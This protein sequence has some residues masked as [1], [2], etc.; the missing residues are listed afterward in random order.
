M[1]KG[2][3]VDF[4]KLDINNTQQIEFIVKNVRD[5]YNKDIAYWQYADTDLSTGLYFAQKDNIFIASQ[6]MIPIYLNVQG[7]KVL[8]AKSESSFLLPNYRGQGIFEKLYSHTIEKSSQSSIH[9]FWGFTSLS[10]VWRRLLSFEV[11]DSIIQESELQISLYRSIFAIRSGS[12]SLFDKCKKLCK[13]IYSEIKLKKRPHIYAEFSA[14]FLDLNNSNHISLIC[15]L[16][17]MWS[18]NHPDYVSMYCDH[19]YIKWRVADNP[20]TKY[21]IIGIYK[22]NL[23]IGMCILNDRKGKSYML[24]FIVSDIDL[25]SLSFDTL[26]LF[27]KKHTLI[28][29]IIYWA[30][31]KNDY[32][33]K[34]HKLMKKYGA[35]IYINEN[36]NF[37]IKNISGTY[38]NID[39]SKYY[40]NG[41]WTEGFKI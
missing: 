23:L 36:M 26:L 8:T 32:S 38:D 27:V 29:H 20:I 14:S 28:S 30:S 1:D 18:I 2:N 3:S 21:E 17:K 39:I 9:C 41:L 40:L 11:F 34:I 24:D 12:S 19:S 33:N 13:S 37:V 35:F 6:G 16:Y 22:N 10:K 15:E 31:N 4:I 7:K 5:F 25:L